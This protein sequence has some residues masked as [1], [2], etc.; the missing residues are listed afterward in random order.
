M[1]L[2]IRVAVVGLVVM[3]A[4]GVARAQGFFAGMRGDPLMLLGQESVQKE[5]KL[6]DEQTKQIGDLRQKTREK[7]QE[8]FQRRRGGAREEDAGAD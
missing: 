5:L 4:Q 8:I 2:I 6:T 1:R 7:F 3:L